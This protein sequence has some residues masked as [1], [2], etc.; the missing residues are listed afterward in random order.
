[1]EIIYGEA[2]LAQ[3][4][5]TDIEPGKLF[6]YGNTT[7]M[8]TSDTVGHGSLCC[9]LADGKLRNI[10]NAANVV[11]VIQVEPIKLSMVISTQ[12]E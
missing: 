9:R 11:M 6:K 5:L 2:T 7:Y 10:N 1:M 4:N 3:T 8:K 12:Q